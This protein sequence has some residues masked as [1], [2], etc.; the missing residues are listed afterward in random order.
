MDLYSTVPYLVS[1]TVLLLVAASPLLKPADVPPN[2][3]GQRLSAFDGMRGFLALAV[4]FHHGVTYHLYILEGTW[5][6]PDSATF[7]LLLGKFGVAG[8]FMITGHLFW[9]KVIASRGN[10]DWSRLYIG[11]F[12]R[13]APLYFVAAALM[14]TFVFYHAGMHWNVPPLKLVKQLGRWL[15]VGLFRGYEFDGSAEPGILLGVAWT[16]QFEWYFYF[17]LPVLALMAGRKRGSPLRPA[18]V[19]VVSVLY[20]AVNTSASLFYTGLHYA[21]PIA[22]FSV[23]MTCAALAENGRNVRL[24]SNAISLLASIMVILAFAAGPFIHSAGEILLLGGVFYLVTCGCSF[25]GLLTCR[26]ARRL[27]DISYGIYLLQ[28]LV[29]SGVFSIG[30]ARRI[31]LASPLGHWSMLLLSAVL[32]ILIATF[33][34]VWI[35]RP[36]I[37]LGKRFGALLCNRSRNALPRTSAVDLAESRTPS[38]ARLAAENYATRQK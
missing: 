12:F 30:W 11:R 29:F 17:S 38:A 4:V 3:H 32:L 19:L 2:P 20:I 33:T 10:M 31:A 1:M 7:Y 37:D 34:H 26:P 16:L 23:G 36:G 13:L 14:L 9:S 8:F 21:E 15:S 22:L 35:E 24:P 27:G 28:N 6:I 18:L 25:F 5:L